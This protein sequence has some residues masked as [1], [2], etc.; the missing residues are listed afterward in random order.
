MVM[1]T[2]VQTQNGFTLI[3]LIVSVSIFVFMTAFLV[4]KYGTFNQS[5]LVTNAAYD[6]ALTIRSA[7]SY[8]LNVQ[9]VENSAFVCPAIN[10]NPAYTPSSFD[11]SYGAFFDT[12]ENKNTTFTLF[13]IPLCLLPLNQVPNVDPST[14]G[15]ENVTILSRTTLKKGIKIEKIC[16]TDGGASAPDCVGS[17]YILFKRPNPG[18]IIKTFSSAGVLTTTSSHDYISITIVSPDGTSKDISVRSTGQISIDN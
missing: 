7:Q 8:G 9:E 13:S 12:D 2:K 15:D 18:A 6:V 10:G 1:K 17:G 14:P 3:E 5:V 4:A 11:Q 16:T